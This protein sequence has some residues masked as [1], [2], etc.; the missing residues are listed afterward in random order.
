[1]KI[2]HKIT[3]NLVKATF[4]ILGTQKL[5]IIKIFISKVNNWIVINNIIKMKYNWIV[6]KFDSTIKILILQLIMLN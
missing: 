2:E 4:L 5:N 6:L 3:K 1:M